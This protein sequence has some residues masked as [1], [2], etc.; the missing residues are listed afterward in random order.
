VRFTVTNLETDGRAVVL[1][2]FY[3]KRGTA[4]QQW[5]KKINKP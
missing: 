5:I 1:V 3:N 2:R 4:E